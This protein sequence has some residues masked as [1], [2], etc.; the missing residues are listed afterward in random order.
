MIDDDHS[1]KTIASSLLIQKIGAW[2]AIGGGRNS[3][4][5][6]ALAEDGATYAVKFY[7]QDTRKRL[8]VEFSGLSFLWNQHVR[9]IPQ[10]LQQNNESHCGIYS[11]LSGEKVV[12]PSSNDVAQMLL[13]VEQLYSLSKKKEATELPA[14]SDACFSFSSTVAII[15]RRLQRLQ[16]VSF[17]CELFSPL[18][19]FLHQQFLPTYTRLRRS[20]NDN[21][22]GDNDS[23]I[24]I[25]KRTLSPSDFGFHNVLRTTDG[26]L[27]F[28]DFEYF[29]WDDPAKMISDVLLHPGMNL[30][31]PLQQQFLDGALS[32]FHDQPQLR[33]RVKRV[34]PFYSLIWCLILLNE[35]VLEDQQRRKFAAGKEIGTDILIEQLQKAE[36][37]L[38]KINKGE[39]FT[40]FG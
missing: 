17:E 36:S 21:H 22:D 25:T 28:L 39:I 26:K 19:H 23:E 3:R 27:F 7:V 2:E 15:E 11:F 33:E 35:F 14:A 13:F 10:P 4:V 29:G 9:N 1:L 6:R 34:I 12:S 18:H 16:A 38:H 30:S 32:I 24:S 31:L 40:L 8:N 5:Y 37:L 20:L